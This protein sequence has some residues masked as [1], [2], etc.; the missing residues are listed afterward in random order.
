LET[1][2]IA[3]RD[4]QPVDVI[5]LLGL[6]DEHNFS[7]QLFQPFAVGVKIPLQCQYPNSHRAAR[8]KS[9]ER[10][11]HSVLRQQMLARLKADG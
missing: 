4:D 2:Q 5:Q 3:T 7:A 8:L 9:A 10:M 11:M 6:L 1:F